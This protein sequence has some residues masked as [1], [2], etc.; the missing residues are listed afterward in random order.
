MVNVP[1]VIS[2]PTLVKPAQIAVASVGDK[3]TLTI[4]NQTL[5]FG[6]EEALKLSQWLRVRG[7]ESKRRAGD[8]S[9]HWS[10]IA[11]L[12]GLTD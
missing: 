10:A 5:T 8:Q 9:R 6:Y 3:V 12:D 11:I 4:N 7:K 1:L 2:K